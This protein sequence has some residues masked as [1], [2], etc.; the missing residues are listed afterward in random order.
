MQ[1][2]YQTTQTLYQNKIRYFNAKPHRDRDKN[3]YLT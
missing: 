1:T 3:Q 2:T